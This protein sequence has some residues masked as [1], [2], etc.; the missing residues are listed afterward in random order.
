MKAQGVVIGKGKEGAER[1]NKSMWGSRKK[2]R[3]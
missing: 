1:Q 2:V 3:D